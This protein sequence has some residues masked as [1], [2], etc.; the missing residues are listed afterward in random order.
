MES[1]ELHRCEHLKTAECVRNLLIY[2]DEHLSRFIHVIRQDKCSICV[3]VYSVHKY[4]VSYSRITFTKSL[5]FYMTTFGASL[6][7]IM[8]LLSQSRDCS[9]Y[10]SRPIPTPRPLLLQKHADLR[11]HDFAHSPDLWHQ[12]RLANVTCAGDCVINPA[13]NVRT[14]SAQP[15]LQVCCSVFNRYAYF[16]TS[17]EICLRSFSEI[18]ILYTAATLTFWRRIFFK[19]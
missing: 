4:K 10:V 8:A 9:W 17:T 7:N 18:R 15:L 12:P 19:F 3:Q 1:Y 13:I 14:F 6:T 16:M 11:A 2:F 5:S